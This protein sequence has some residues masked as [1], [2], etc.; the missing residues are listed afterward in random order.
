MFTS[1]EIQ[2]KI[3]QTVSRCKNAIHIKDDILVH[4]HGKAHDDYLGHILRV[5][6]DNGITFRLAKCLL[7]Q[8]DV[9]W[10]GNIYSK[11]GMST[12]PDKCKVIRN[13]PA[14]V[15]CNEVKSFLQ[16]V[17]FNAK[18]LGCKTGELFYPD[19]TEPLR[20][21]TKKN[22]HFIWGKREQESFEESKK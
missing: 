8:L 1:S 22:A 2:K 3:R 10:F 17:Q 5:L 11:D 7:G 9:K 12:D 20:A 16:T 4:G 14:P 21:M 13:W 18:F 6:E 15:N 19:L